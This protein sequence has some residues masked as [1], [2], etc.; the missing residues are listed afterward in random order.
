MLDIEKRLNIKFPKEY[1]DFINNMDAI[2][3]KKIILLDEEENIVIKN[4]LSLDEE[5]E[6]SIT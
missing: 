6:D 2:N 1:I 5:I 3:S 4:F